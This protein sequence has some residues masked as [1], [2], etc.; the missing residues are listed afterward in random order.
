MARQ[1]SKW[2][3]LT[4]PPPNLAKMSDLVRAWT[5]WAYV[6]SKGQHPIADDLSPS[7]QY[8]NRL[9]ILD[10]VFFLAGTYKN[11]HGKKVNRS[12]TIEKDKTVFFP[13]VNCISS[14]LE[15]NRPVDILAKDVATENNNFYQAGSY[16]EIDG[17]K[18]VAKIQKINSGGPFLLY[19][20]AK[21]YI[22]QHT[23]GHD[24]M[25]ANPA[26]KATNGVCAG[27]WVYGKFNNAS[28]R[29]QHK[30]AFQGTLSAGQGF[31][32]FETL[33]EYS[34]KIV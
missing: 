16:V 2:S 33:V 20:N 8:A 7:N 30:I 19:M 34:I 23:K 3:N 27:H 31:P 15:D 26:S 18:Q 25:K 6:N 22:F 29:E 14:V 10:N 12:C 32:A 11:T 1:T 17:D 5:T 9:Q 28:R 4:T 21:T 13:V 24:S